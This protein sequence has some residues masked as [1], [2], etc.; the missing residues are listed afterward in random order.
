MHKH[1]SEV[2]KKDESYIKD[3]GDELTKSIKTLT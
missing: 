2:I 3:Q 1:D